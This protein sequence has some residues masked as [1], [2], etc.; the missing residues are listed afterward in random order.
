MT[1]SRYVRE[2]VFALDLAQLLSNVNPFELQSALLAKH[3]T[4]KSNQE[5][6]EILY[7]WVAFNQ[8]DFRAFDQVLRYLRGKNPSRLE[9]RV[10]TLLGWLWKNDVNSIAAAPSEIWSGVDHSLPLQLCKADF[11]IR[12]G[13]LLQAENILSAIANCVCP[14]M[15]ML[16]ASLLSKRGDEQAAIELLLSYLDRC[17]RH[18]RYYRQ[19]LAHMIDGKDSQNILAC[20]NQALSIFGEDPEILFHFTTLNLYKRQPG[21]AKRSALLQQVSASIRPTSINLGN[22]ATYEMNGRLT[23]C[24]IFARDYS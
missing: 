24:V 5:D 11:Y 9:V 20:A 1:R 12:Q 14:E 2:F 15:A 21:L 23:G 8:L 13:R 7:C 22:H 10:L 3:A 17:P 16:Q 18:I 6:C 19:L 4:E